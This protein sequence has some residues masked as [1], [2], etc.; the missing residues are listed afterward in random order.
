MSV[1]ELSNRWRAPTVF[2]RQIAGIFGVPI[3]AISKEK[4]SEEQ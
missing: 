2:F 3:S 1:K 4:P